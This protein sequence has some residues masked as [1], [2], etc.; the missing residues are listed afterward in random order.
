[1]LTSEKL[2]KEKLLELYNMDLDELLK[3]SSRF[4]KNEVEFCSLVNARNGKC[5]QD[6]KY[7]AQSSH[8][9]TDIE[10]YPLISAEAVK[11]AA[12]EAK[13]NHVSRFAVVTS[14][15]S[16]DESDLDGIINLIEEINKIDGL[17]SCASIGILTEEQAKRL[18]DCGLKRFHHNIN[19][20]RSYYDKV[21]TT[22]S[23]EDRLNTCKLVKKYGMELCCGVIL[24][25]GET[26]EQR[27]EMALEL[28]EIEPESIPINILMPI[29]QTPFENYLDKIDEE[30]VL[31]TL[32][33]F[34]IANPKS[35]LRF[36]GGR[37][38]LSEE[39]QIKALKSCV[40]G[41]MTGNYLTTTGKSPEDDIELV[42]RLG[43]AIK[44]NF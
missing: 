29:P 32:A 38:R 12:L 36:C 27:V 9:R 8:Y 41:L 14:G 43:L 17:R 5:S 4:I 2:T 22:H 44:T 30:N 28:A 26:I 39:N 18:A 10:S 7:C 42:H 31:R 33:I 3:L 13:E 34:K 21:C 25:M 37:M 23:W 19:T 24:G 16:P 35:I 6:C 20:A 15:K 11:K 1:M 40:E